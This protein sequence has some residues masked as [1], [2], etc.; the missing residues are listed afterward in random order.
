MRHLCILFYIIF[1][2]YANASVNPKDLHP[3]LSLTVIFTVTHHTQRKR[4]YYDDGR[5]KKNVERYT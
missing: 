5:M 2:L 1:L 4:E 3:F